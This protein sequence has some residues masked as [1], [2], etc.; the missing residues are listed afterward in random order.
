MPH[1]TRHPLAILAAVAIRAVSQALAMPAAQAGPSPG[2]RASAGDF[3]SA[4]VTRLDMDV[5][6]KSLRNTAGI[7]RRNQ[8]IALT[9]QWAAQGIPLQIQYTIPVEQYGLD[10]DGEAVLQHA[11]ADGATVTA[12]TPVTTRQIVAFDGGPAPGRTAP[13][14]RYSSS[15]TPAGTSAAQPAIA[16]KD[17]DPATTAAAASANTAATG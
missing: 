12:S 5:E 11:A 8:V 7:N 6:A 9:E 10:P 15:S 14:R 1:A 13:L 2:H 17:R 3:A 4:G 16:V